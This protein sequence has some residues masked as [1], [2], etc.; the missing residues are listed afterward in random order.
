LDGWFYV[1]DQDELRR[2]EPHTLQERYPAEVIARFAPYL[3][4]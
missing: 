2:V 4:V 3:P 1:L